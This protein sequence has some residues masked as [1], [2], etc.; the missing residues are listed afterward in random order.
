[1]PSV[2]IVSNHIRAVGKSG[3]GS[4]ESAEFTPSLAHHFTPGPLLD[5]HFQ[6]RYYVSVQAPALRPRGA[7]Q[8]LVKPGRKVLDCYIRHVFLPFPKNAK[9]YH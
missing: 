5:G 4:Q 2:P 1:M 7:L 8:F 6:N 3:Q 9:C